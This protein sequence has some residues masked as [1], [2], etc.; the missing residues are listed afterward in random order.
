[1]ELPPSSSS[2]AGSYL[3][4]QIQQLFGD[5]LVGTLQV[6]D[7]VPSEVAVLGGQQGV[8]HPLLARAAGAADPVRV[9]VDVPSHVVVDDSLDGRDI[10][11]S[12]C[13]QE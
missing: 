9:G 1:M 10:Q 6:P 8:G 7:E 3:H 13:N 12:S 4:C 5:V 2:F 11:A